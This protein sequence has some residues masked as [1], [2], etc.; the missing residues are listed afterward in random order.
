MHIYIYIV[1]TRL[2]SPPNLPGGAAR[3]RQPFD[4]ICLYPVIPL[5]RT[6]RGTDDGYIYKYVYVS[7]IVKLLQDQVF[8]SRLYT[9]FSVWYYC[10]LV[11]GGDFF[12]FISE[13]ISCAPR[14]SHA[15]DEGSTRSAGNKVAIARL[16]ARIKHLYDNGSKT[17]G[18]GG[19]FATD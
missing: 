5:V 6:T 2:S 3:T 7:A 1:W 9:T 14:I 15:R 10:Y 19:G 4:L 12:F 8:S 11:I 13:G 17:R 18:R 16:Y